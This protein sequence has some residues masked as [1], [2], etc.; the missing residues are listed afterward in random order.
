MVTT[1]HEQRCI[2]T[3]FRRYECKYVI[4]EATA[5]DIRAYARPYV[6]PDPYTAASP[7][8]SYDINSLYLDSPDL[9]L[10][11]ETQEGQ[12]N[13][14]K[15]RIRTYDDAEE[16]PVFLEIKRRFNSQVLKGRARI[17]RADMA[18]ILAGGAPDT[19]ALPGDQRACHEEF[20]GWMARLIAQPVVWVRYRRE[21]YVGF[22]NRDIRITMDR[23]LA[24]A[25]TDNTAGPGQ[26]LSWLPV[27]SRRVVLEVKFDESYPDWVARLVQRFRLE[28]R[29]YSKY[30]RSVLRGMADIAPTRLKAGAMAS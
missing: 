20:V 12:L 14:I 1:N 6:D 9:R 10:F 4:S 21:A 5:M 15:L 28:K 17:S 23:A 18:F 27:E 16:S 30:G 26:V 25:P 29:S 22:Y 13:R 2:K 7:D 11:S 24:C 19:S 8:H 3:R